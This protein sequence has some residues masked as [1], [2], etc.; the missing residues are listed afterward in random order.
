RAEWN[1]IHT[2]RSAIGDNIAPNHSY[3]A[4]IVNWLVWRAI[5]TGGNG[6]L[7]HESGDEHHVA[8]KQDLSNIHLAQI[9]YFFAESNPEQARVAAYLR[10][11]N[12]KQDM[13]GFHFESIYPFL[14]DWKKFDPTVFKPI[15]PDATWAHAR[16][17]E[18]LGEFHL[19]S[20]FGPDDTYCLFKAG[21]QGAGHIHKDENNFHIYNHGF[22]AMDTGCRDQKN[23]S[24]QPQITEYYSQTIAHNCITID[25]PGEKF[26]HHWGV[27][28]KLNGGGQNAD[29]G[30]VIRAFST[31]DHYSYINSDATKV[32]CEAK[33]G[34]VNR[35][36][37]F[38][39]P[40]HF[41]VIDRVTSTNATFAKR[42]LLHFQNEPQRDGLTVR[43]DHGTGRI[44][45][46]TLFPTNAKLELIGGPGKENTVAG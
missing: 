26:P 34:L 6:M 21:N 9:Q 22:L 32:Y 4:N 36:F 15:G 31:S 19:R 27:V 46:R 18:Y 39:H 7:C 1:F 13:E 29:K 16:H 14:L 2:W 30:T 43:A 17:F 3:I 28:P 41:V 12:A 24:S 44:F 37:I 33:A 5:Y 38:I 10:Q 35:Q 20:G 8:N 25:M 23:P 45:S 40:N 42:W 11:V